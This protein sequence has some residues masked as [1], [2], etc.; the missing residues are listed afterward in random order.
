MKN[1]T[2]TEVKE[3]YNSLPLDR[4]NHILYNALDYMQSYNGRSKIQCIAY[5]MG[6]E[7]N[8][9]DETNQIIYTKK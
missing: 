7:S 2:S 6:Y 5:A 8:W 4:K 1:I 9:C 3:I